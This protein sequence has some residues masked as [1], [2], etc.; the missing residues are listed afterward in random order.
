M[1]G[2]PSLR[3]DVVSVTAGRFRNGVSNTD[4]DSIRE[5]REGGDL[6]CFL[7]QKY[8]AIIVKVLCISG[9]SCMVLDQV[10]SFLFN[11]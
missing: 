3:N 6:L 8:Y 5:S 10:K 11:S 9:V 4:E 7:S 1:R 2:N